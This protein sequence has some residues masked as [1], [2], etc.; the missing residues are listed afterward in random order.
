M[1]RRSAAQVGL[2]KQPWQ[3]HRIMPGIMT[4]IVSNSG[5]RSWETF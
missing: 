5:K 2:C 4:R 1:V 3:K